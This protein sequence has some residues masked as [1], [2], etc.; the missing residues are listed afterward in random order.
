MS[1]CPVTATSCPTFEQ[2][3]E[4][5][6]SAV[7]DSRGRAT[8]IV[9]YGTIAGDAYVRATVPELGLRDSIR[10]VVQPGA[11]AGV[12]LSPGDTAVLQGRTF[13][14]RGVVVDRFGNDRD[15]PVHF[16]APTGG[17][18]TVE[19]ATGRLTAVAVGRAVVVAAA[20]ERADTAMVSVVPEGMI[21]ALQAWPSSE[22]IV[23]TALD[24]SNRRGY[25]I[26]GGQAGT[27]GLSWSADGARLLSGGHPNEGT[28]P[29]SAL[30][31]ASGSI[32][33]IVTNPP[34]MHAVW[35][36]RYSPDGQWVY[37]NAARDGT[38][39]VAPSHQRGR[40]G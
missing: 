8:V 16:T 32:S 31:V 21:A 2:A 33:P 37:F 26:P 7:T 39:L 10:F 5:F 6:T 1:I 13:N 29:L 4:P 20:G 12:R 19:D 25:S 3:Y 28:M 18:V 40:H 22:P 14:L 15:D 30:E 11:A 34:G 27:A 38:R 24:G 23:A 36:G 35:W 9:R 17:A